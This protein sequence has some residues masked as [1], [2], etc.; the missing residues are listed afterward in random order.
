MFDEEERSVNCVLKAHLAGRTCP[1]NAISDLIFQ[2]V[3][4]AVAYIRTRI[5]SGERHAAKTNE[6]SRQKDIWF[7]RAHYG[8]KIHDGLGML[9]DS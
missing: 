9:H 6:Q 5:V 4:T 8:W 7:I 1:I 2:C 3:N